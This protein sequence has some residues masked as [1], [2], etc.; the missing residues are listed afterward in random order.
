MKGSNISLIVKLK[1]DLAT[2]LRILKTSEINGDY[3]ISD[4]DN[5]RIWVDSIKEILDS[6][7]NSTLMIIELGSKDATVMTVFQME[8]ALTKLS[9]LKQEIN[10]VNLERL[11][12]ALFKLLVKDVISILSDIS[13]LIPNKVTDKK[14]V[15]EIKKSNRFKNFFN[16]KGLRVFTDAQI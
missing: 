1:E 7:G 16:F 4:I 13:Q 14:V 15:V 8:S 6:L 2:Y 12:N 9:K 11:D 10:S 3:I 5:K